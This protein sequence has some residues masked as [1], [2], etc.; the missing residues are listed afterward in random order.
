MKRI[1]KI[2]ISTIVITCVLGSLTQATLFSQLTTKDSW[3]VG[4]GATF[5]KIPLPLS[6]FSLPIS[7]LYYEQ[8]GTD[9]NI[10]YMAFGF[11][12]FIP[13]PGVEINKTFGKAPVELSLG[14]GGFADLLIGGHC[15]I[16]LRAGLRILGEY[17]LNLFAIPYGTANSVN[18]STFEAADVYSTIQFPYY[19]LMLSKHFDF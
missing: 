2:F 5:N 14:A 16:T 4:V 13:V 7:Y 19:G 15:G 18:Y 9:F 12:G 6:T 3:G 8:G 10:R 11:D 17:E 1:K